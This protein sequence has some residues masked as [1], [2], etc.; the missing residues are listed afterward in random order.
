MNLP[1]LTARLVARNFR[2]LRD[3]L[4]LV[5]VGALV[6][7]LLGY[8]YQSRLA[9]HLGAAVVIAA[10]IG[11]LVVGLAYLVTL[12]FKE[13]LWLGLANVLVPFYAVYYWTTRWHKMKRPV[14]NTAGSF[15]P[16]A[17]VALAYLVYK[18]APVVETAIERDFPAL[19]E[20]VG[21][22]LPGLEKGVDRVLGPVTES[23]DRDL[24]TGESNDGQRAPEASPR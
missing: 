18:E 24:N 16:I 9:L 13:S 22:K 21:K 6:V 19:E 2:S 3:W 20:R 17:L 23:V 8:L 12:P 14:L 15:L 5:S 1:T 10:N 7:V 11:M 4:Y